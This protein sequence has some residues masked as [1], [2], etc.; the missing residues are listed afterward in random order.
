MDIKIPAPLKGGDRIAILS[1]ATTVKEEYVAGAENFLAEQ[2]YAPMVLPGATGPADGSFA[3]SLQS[4]VADMRFAL[5]EPSIKAILC[6]RGG[7]GCIQ[8]LP[9]LPFSVVADNPKWIIGFS[10]VSALHALWLK[11]G[12]ASLHAPMAK[13]LTLEGADDPATITLLDI[14]SGKAGMDYQTEPHPFNRF[15]RAR[16]RLQGGNI[17]V[18]NGLAATPYDIL[19][20]SEGEDVILFIEDI[21]EAIYA[22]ERML[23][24]LYLAGSLQ[25]LKG[26][27]V[28]Q[29]TEYRP[30]LNHRSMEEMIHRLLLRL[31]IKD[32]PV[33]F[34]F[35][36]GHVKDNLPMI[37]GATVDFEVAPHSV[38]LRSVK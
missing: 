30:D 14:L 33:A 38:I 1:P 2:G 35:P 3:S 16:G 18:L 10:D 22:V 11:A 19:D 37:E 12:V 20:V 36:V 27:I 29:F 21:S 17:A 15:G 24:R 32:I 9:E 8:M 5:T 6:A 31:G 7:Y 23:M 28:G 34:N 4:R 13:H 26:L 25:R